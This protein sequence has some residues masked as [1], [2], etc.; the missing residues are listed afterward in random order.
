MLQSIDPKNLFVKAYIKYM[1]LHFPKYLFSGRPYF[2]N[3]VSLFIQRCRKYFEQRL[4]DCHSDTD[5]NWQTGT[6][7]SP[8]STPT[9]CNE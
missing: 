2:P 6:G 1:H 4:T 3:K 5:Q 9:I 8:S 7:P